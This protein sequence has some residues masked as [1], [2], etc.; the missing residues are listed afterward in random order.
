MV[1]KLLLKSLED[2]VDRF[3]FFQMKSESYATNT[4]RGY[5]EIVGKQ[6]EE[7]WNPIVKFSN[8]KKYEQ[9]KFYGSSKTFS[10]WYNGSQTMQ[11]GEEFQLVS[12]FF[13]LEV[14][15]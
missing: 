5:V 12:H 13:S 15:H 9:T 2:Y 10:F 3:F 14:H 6:R 4:F 7:V 1:S 8:V 11:Y